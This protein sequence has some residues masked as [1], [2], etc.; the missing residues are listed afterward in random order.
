MKELSISRRALLT[1]GIGA[2]GALAL[3][4]ASFAQDAEGVVEMVLGADDAPVT[5]YEYA[6]YTCP[7][8]ASFHATTFKELK[9]AYIDTGK[10]RFVFR[11]VYFDKYGVWASLIA[12]C[13]GQERFF[14]ITDLMFQGQT[15]WARQSS[16]QAILDALLKIG[17]L[18]GM[19][20]TTMMACLQNKAE[21][22]ALVGWYQENATRD[23]V[24]STPSLLIDGELHS[25]LSFDELSTI[26]DSK[27]GS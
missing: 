4:R 21:I 20:D 13:G 17:R 14:G 19:D 11:E 15:D 6:S 18:A 9:K 8:C 23:N 16:D 22:Q 3:P 26:I 24:K 7:H 27:L 5:L 25:N 10:L 1:T 12:R 2:L